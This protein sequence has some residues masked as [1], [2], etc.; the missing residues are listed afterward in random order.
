MY[1]TSRILRSNKFRGP[2]GRDELKMEYRSALAVASTGI[3]GGSNGL[4]SLACASVSSIVRGASF[5]GGSGKS[6]V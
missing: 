1:N 4:P 2:T 3:V 6:M 5:A